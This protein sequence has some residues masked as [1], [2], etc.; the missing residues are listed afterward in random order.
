MLKTY[1][2]YNIYQDFL[3]SK[4]DDLYGDHFHRWHQY[5]RFLKS[6]TNLVITNYCETHANNLITQ[7][8]TGRGKSKCAIESNFKRFHKSIVPNGYGL[9]DSFFMNE[10]CETNQLK[11]RKRNSHYFGFIS[12]HFNAFENLAFINK[13][14]VIP[15]RIDNKINEFTSWDILNDYLLPFSD[16]IIID[17]YLFSET[18]PILKI[19]IGKILQIID[20]KAPKR[21]NLLIITYRGKNREINIS[22]IQKF[23][24]TI[25]NEC[26]LKANISVIATS[27]IEHD[28]NI[29]MNYMRISSKH[30]FNYLGNNCTPMVK[31]EIEFLSYADSENFEN[32]Q[33]ILKDV[34]SNICK[35]LDKRNTSEVF[36]NCENRLLITE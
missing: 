21:Y 34:S 5:W 18:D 7:L 9:S 11:Y 6:S 25:K 31:S 12:D 22:N 15:I 26:S 10:T 8:T 23:L 17:N 33:V 36:G 1:Y 32:A 30:S 19:N 27:K 35:V 28:R 20:N 29:F 2:D 4:P 14:K 13:K 3:K 24:L 16:C